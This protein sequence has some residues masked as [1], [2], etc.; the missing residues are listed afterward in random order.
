[1]PKGNSTAQKQTFIWSRPI[2]LLMSISRIY[3]R[4]MQRRLYN[5]LEIYNLL[6][7]KQFGFRK[8]HC[9]IDALAEFTEIIPLVSEET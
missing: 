4:V 6:C 7:D 8:K 9:T 3:E 2:S 5:Y 1:M